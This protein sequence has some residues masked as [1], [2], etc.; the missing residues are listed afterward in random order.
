MSLFY[1]GAVLA[2]SKKQEC[3]H[4]VCSEC[5]HV[6]ESGGFTRDY[7]EWGMKAYFCSLHEPNWD[8][9]YIEEHRERGLVVRTRVIYVKE[10]SPKEVTPNY[11]IP[12]S[13]YSIL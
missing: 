11:K 1:R 6:Y 13:S 4:K 3:A 7:G 8:K 12:L 9:V 5:G 2:L 10:Q